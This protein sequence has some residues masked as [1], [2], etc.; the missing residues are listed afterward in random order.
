MRILTV[1][2]VFQQAWNFFITSL[3]S[4]LAKHSCQGP[5]SS[6]GI[7]YESLHYPGPAEQYHAIPLV[8]NTGKIPLINHAVQAPIQYFVPNNGGENNGQS[9]T[10][11]DPSSAQHSPTRRHRPAAAAPANQPD[12]A[13]L[14]S[15]TLSPSPRDAENRQPARTA[16][17]SETGTQQHNS[18]HGEYK[19]I[20]GNVAVGRHDDDGPPGPD[21]DF[22]VL[23]TIDPSAKLSLLRG[24]TDGPKPVRESN[25]LHAHNNNYYYVA[26]AFRPIVVQA[27][28]DTRVRQKSN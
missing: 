2:S 1:Y 22:A 17:Y 25:G 9:T 10:T 4:V 7:S 6:S 20:V 8:I 18:S 3:L 24:A 19:I 28:T 11:H 13:M 26:G 5:A 23:Q 21:R 14:L 27:A 15:R 12:A 16:I